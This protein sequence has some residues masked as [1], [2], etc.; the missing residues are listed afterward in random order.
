M[1][2]APRNFVLSKR[3]TACVVLAF[4]AFLV[5]FTYWERAVMVEKTEYIRAREFVRSSSSVQKEFGEITKIERQRRFRYMQSFTGRKE[6]SGYFRFGVEGTK[7]SGSVTLH[8]EYYPD[9]QQFVATRL[10]HEEPL[11]RS[12]DLAT[13]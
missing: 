13:K 12:G 7:S 1:K 5:G 8:W 3:T 4:V 11:D 10:V 6:S 9:T 2:V